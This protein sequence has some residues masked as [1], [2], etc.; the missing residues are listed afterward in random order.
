MEVRIL[1]LDPG[2]ANTGY[3][4]L[5]GNVESREINIHSFGLLKTTKVNGG[6]KE[7]RER[8]DTLGAGLRKLIAEYR[9]TH[10]AIEDFTE[11]GKLVGKTYKEMSWLVEHFR[12]VGRELGLS[13]AVYENAEW[14]RTLLKAGHAN[15]AQVQHYVTHRLSEARELLH[16]Q[17]DHVWDSVAIGLCTFASLSGR[18]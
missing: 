16:K 15:K 13:V 2:T 9:P 1:G 10:L 17:P 5:I 6:A 14:K 4:H 8:V 12:M 3:S 18:K 7:V 11:Q